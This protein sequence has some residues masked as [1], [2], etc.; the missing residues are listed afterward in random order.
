MSI[1]LELHHEVLGEGP[2]LVI[3]HGLFGS[4]DNWRG[5]ARKLAR[6][7]R[8]WLVDQ[9]N[10][11]RSPHSDDFCYDA[12]V[13][14]LRA[15]LDRH[16]LRRV[17]LLGHSMGGKTAMLFASM[18]PERID[19]LIVEDMG[20][21]GYGPR[22]DGIFR[23]LLG[24]PLSRLRSRGEADRR[25]RETVPEAGVRG[26][27]LKNL[28]RRESGGWSW[29]CNL[30]I[31][32]AGYRHLL[33]PL[34]LASPILCPT[35]FVRGELSDYLPSESDWQALDLFARRDLTTIAGAGHWVHADRPDAFLHAVESFLLART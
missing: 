12:M 29:R 19:R 27:L 24:L 31:L 16:G 30:P 21:W 8:V 3:L 2:D 9:R 33:A 34:P 23:G 7:F 4:L 11:G 1:P 25:L 10:H 35:L 20:P 14:D 28:Q 15:L 26:F 18:H 32:F 13:M 17:H 5:P 22:H 6:R